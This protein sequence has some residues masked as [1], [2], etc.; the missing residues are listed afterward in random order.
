MFGHQTFKVGIQNRTIKVES[1]S[2]LIKKGPTFLAFPKQK[3][4]KRMGLD[5]L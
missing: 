3:K 1:N 2:S 4:K 5:P